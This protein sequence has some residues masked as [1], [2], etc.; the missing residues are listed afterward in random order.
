VLVLGFTAFL[1]VGVYKYHRTV[2]MSIYCEKHQQAVTR[3][4]TK[5]IKMAAVSFVCLQ[6]CIYTVGVFY[7]STTFVNVTVLGFLYE[8]RK[9]RLSARLFVC[10]IIFRII[11]NFFIKVFSKR[12]LSRASFVKIVPETVT[13]YWKV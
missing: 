13:F 8:V 9:R 1:C 6:L 10:S 4:G 11:T 3:G 2:P 12:C 5:N 7:V